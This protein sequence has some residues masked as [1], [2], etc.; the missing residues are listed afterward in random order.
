MEIL[1]DIDLK[2]VR[3]QNAVLKMQDP[4]TGAKSMHISSESTSSDH[5]FGCTGIVTVAVMA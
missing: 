1:Q 5:S 3:I 2:Q 4:A